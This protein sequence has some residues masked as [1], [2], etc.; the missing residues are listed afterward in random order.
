[1]EI[2]HKT[3]YTEKNSVETTNTDFKANNSWITLKENRNQDTSHAQPDFTKYV[4]KVLQ[5]RKGNS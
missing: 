2:N 3:S 4:N 5:A 1:M